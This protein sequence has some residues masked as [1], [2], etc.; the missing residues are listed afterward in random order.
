[1]KKFLLAFLAVIPMTQSLFAEKVTLNNKEYE[2]TTLIDRDL[3][4]GVRYTRLRV[5][6]YPLNVNMLRID[7]TNPYNSVETTQGADK[8]Y[9]TESLVNAA[10]RQTSDGHIALAGAN[11]NFWCV[12]GQPPYSA[13]VSGVTYNGNMRNGKIITETNMTSDQWNHGYTH[14]G[15]VG[16]TEDKQ[17]MS[18]YFKWSGTVSSDVF[19]TYEFQ[20]ANKLVRDEEISIYNSYYPSSR[21][22]RCVNQRKDDSNTWVFDI[23]PNCATEVYLTL[24]QGQKWSAG[25]PITFTVDKVKTNAGAG[26]LGT[27]DLAIVGR[28]SK[29]TALA[30]LSAGDK[31]TVQYAWRTL[32]DKPVKFANLVGGNAQ[33]MVDGE[34]TTHNTTETYNSQVYSRTGYGTSADN[35]TLYIM[36]IDKASDPVYGSSA[37]CSTTI[38]CQ[39]L[40]HYGCTNVTNFDAGGSAEMLVGNKIINTTTEGNPRAV[41]NGMIVYNIAPTDNVITRLEF[42]DHEL[43]APIYGSYTPQVLGYNQYGALI[44]ENVNVTLSCDE[45]AGTCSGN[46]FTAGGTPGTYNLTA[47]YGDASV[48]VPIVVVNAQMAIR[49][50]P[51]LIDATRQYPIEVLA[52]VDGQEYTYDPASIDWTVGDPDIID[53]NA[54]GVITGLKNGQT[55]LT[56]KIGDF[57]DTATV[58]VE[59]AESPVMNVQNWDDWVAKGLTGITSSTVKKTDSTITFTYAKN[60]RSP[61][62]TVTPGDDYT[63]YSLPDAI[64]MTF[65]STLPVSSVTL[66]FKNRLLERAQK[67]VVTNDTPLAAN[68][69][70]TV[71]FPFPTD[72]KD[73][74]TY[75]LSTSQVAVSFDK[76][77]DYVGDHTLDIKG[78]TAHYNNFTEGVT[79]VA[80]DTNTVDPNAPEVYYNLQ[81]V[82]VPANNLTP[83]LYIKVKGNKATKLLINN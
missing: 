64:S 29:A 63:F 55:T 60:A 33:V 1:M 54:N 43:K 73:L 56:A 69:E 51:L 2:V 79:N 28:G 3:G 22:F 70:H 83:G 62:I 80:P 61:Q 26:T 81:G 65:T 15:I 72:S 50:N 30:K 11:A 66:S 27:Y 24:D 44:S 7:V 32:D 71:E 9:S 35:K 46:R 5:P 12:S 4:P 10:K 20:S 13:Q 78:L 23:V 31:V 82:R 25:D 38:M 21:T 40:S 77:N 48:T 41:A 76:S 6:A 39:L 52:T 37:G 8:L 14:T 42:V 57:T 17:A 45:T 59:V 47:T 16:V 49:I 75:P 58:T 18:G 68:T 36:V 19:G 74:M 53:V 67:V 34:L